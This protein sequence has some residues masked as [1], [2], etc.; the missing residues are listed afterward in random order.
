[1]HKTFKKGRTLVLLVLRYFKMRK[2]VFNRFTLVSVAALVILFGILMAYQ[3]TGITAFSIINNDN[4]SAEGKHAMTTTRLLELSAQQDSPEYTTIKGQKVLKPKQLEETNQN[5]LN[6]DKDSSIASSIQASDD[7]LNA[8]IILEDQPLH[9]I[10]KE[11]K[12]QKKGAI[13]AKKAELKSINQ[14]TQVLDEAEMMSM[15]AAAAAEQ[16]SAALTSSEKARKKVLIKEI[17]SDLHELRKSILAEAASAVS[18]AQDDIKQ[19]VEDCGGTYVSSNSIINSVSAIIPLSC[20]DDLED[21]ALAVYES[22]LVRVELD[23]SI[24]ST[25]AST[26]YSAGYNGSG[27]DL[28]V[29]DTGIDGTHPALTVDAAQTFHT[30]AQLSPT[31]NDNPAST[32][33]LHGHGTHCAGI[34]TSTDSTY[35]GVAYG[36]ADLINTKF[37]WKGTDNNGYG[38]WPDAMDGIHWAINT[39]GA[40]TISFSFG[41]SVGSDDCSMCRFMDA[42]VDSLDVSVAV[43]AGNSG[44]GSTTVGDPG[45]AYNIFSVAAMDDK[46]TTSRSDDYIASY[47]SRGYTTGGRIKPDIA[48]PG[49]KIYSAAYNWEG[50]NADF[51][52]KWGTSMAAPHV[53]AATLL[54][55]DYT[56]AWDPKGIK[57]LLL[58]TAE[59]NGTF[60]SQQAYGWG[61]MDL[62]H[63]YVHRDDVFLTSVAENRAY[64]LYKGPAVSGDKATLVWNRHATY[65]NNNYPSIYSSL[66]D[67]D[68]Y[69]YN[70]DNGAAVDSSYSSIDNVEQVTAAGSYDVVVKVI[71]YTADF[72]HGSNTEEFA[73]ATEEG[74]TAV[75]GP[76]LEATQQYNHT[77]NDTVLPLLINVTMNNSG[78]TSAHSI[79]V[80]ITLPQGLTMASGSANKTV[81]IINNGS[82]SQAV[83]NITA[84]APGSFSGIS[85][86]Y[87]ASNYGLSFS[88]STS[89]GSLYITDDDSTPPSFFAWNYTA[90]AHPDDNIA[91]RVNITDASGIN[92]STLYYDYSDDG[93][94]DGAINMTQ[95]SPAW[96]A[97]IPAPGNM[98]EG[99]NVS[100]VVES[101]DNDYDRANDSMKINSSEQYVFILN[102]A[103][104]LTIHSPN[105]SHYF[106]TNVSLNI[107]AS[108][109]VAWLRLSTDNGA[110]DTLC[111]NCT[112]NISNIN[113]S[114]GNHS[115]AV[116]AE[117]YAGNAGSADVDFVVDP[118]APVIHNYNLADGQRIPG[119]ADTLFLVNYSEALLDSVVLSLNST[120]TY[121]S[122]CS[123]GA[124]QACS[125]GMNLSA[126]ADGAVLLF[127]FTINETSGRN[128]SLLNASNSSYQLVIDR[129]APVITFN[130]PA[131][132]S[133]VGYS[134]TLNISSDEAADLSY[135]LDNS[136][137]VSLCSDCTTGSAGLSNL[138][139]SSHT[140][141]ALA[142]DEAGNTGSST[143]MFNVSP[144][145]DR[146]GVPDRLDPDDD[147]DN[148]NDTDDRLLGNESHLDTNMD[149]VSIEVNGSS[150]LSQQFNGTLNLTFKENDSVVVEFEFDF[151]NSTLNLSNI[152]IRK[153]DSAVTGSVLIRGIVLVNRT[154]IAYVDD[155]N[156]SISTLCIKDAEVDS[157]DDITSSCSGTDEY[158]ITCPGSVS[159]YTCTVNGSKYRVTGL[160]YS[161]LKELYV[162]PSPPTGGGGG[163]GG[164]GSAVSD[165]NIAPTSKGTYAT[166]NKHGS[167]DLFLGGDVYEFR[168]TN[169]GLIDIMFGIGDYHYSLSSFSPS[170]NI[171]IDKD[172]RYDIT[173]V[174]DSISSRKATL[175]FKLY[176]EPVRPSLPVLPAN[177]SRQR[178]QRAAVEPSD[179]ASGAEA[180]TRPAA[181]PIPPESEKP[182][183]LET[184]PPVE[185]QKFWMRKSVL[186]SGAAL[187]VLLVVVLF[188]VFAAKKRPVVTGKATGPETPA[189]KPEET[190]QPPKAEKPAPAKPEKPSP[191]AAPPKQKRSASSKKTP[192]SPKKSPASSSSTIPTKRGPARSVQEINN[193]ISSIKNRLGK[194]K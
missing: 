102:T 84:T 77:I 25:L 105:T 125:V 47:S 164:G 137:S 8:I 86:A 89:P 101:A 133:E 178:R 74:F 159:S 167:A 27:F 41:G 190:T 94:F 16:E 108:E 42:V 38:F 2:E 158:Y 176:E 33:D 115:L 63:A 56:G 98:H 73:L 51:V 174:L 172:S 11:K 29:A 169:I 19:V 55:L 157:I 132:N 140:I 120:Q 95:N 188:F 9:R 71:S 65:N 128:N 135:S 156:G 90:T 155:I 126:Y 161:A 31:Y 5:L 114:E 12:Q 17:N 122:N 4:A 143:I 13:E 48:A 175:V 103:P 79:W 59:S 49:S 166:I 3:E 111:Y 23:V 6:L 168:L 75:S 58:N 36:M 87:S 18:S 141:H 109:E 106:S 91:V 76:S 14:K 92:Y 181:A 194:F 147:N 50:G 151:T 28:T 154:K 116:F 44:P 54:V 21:K 67:L 20:L 144:D 192:A 179:T 78:D 70:E 119:D 26:W 64:K 66:N 113:L 80:N 180:A 62:N 182:A 30:W 186:A 82:T 165:I 193:E 183:V 39:A 22:K 15:G 162:A 139:I 173:V 163:G 69:M 60:T 117:D 146:D 85:A 68:L 72:S 150:N 112:A 40:D 93:I 134:F 96:N 153:Q 61:Y 46:S 131:N 37:G 43:S 45:I 97:T 136:S 145:I 121:L 189:T 152:T 57:A 185:A 52:D 10:S 129:T 124:F 32:D 160:S 191:K 34:V 53:A 100:F 170:I 99:R 187:L 24:P 83:F 130:S 35:K 149:N 142:V 81:T 118:S 104:V 148:I 7:M 184:L 177:Y 88:G 171:D 107:S 123:A 1:L 110:N 127:Y 138:S